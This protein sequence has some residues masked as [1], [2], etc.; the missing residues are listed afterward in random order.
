[1]IE[2]LKSLLTEAK[3]DLESASDDAQVEATRIKYLG[4]KGSLSAVLRGMGK[5]AAEERP[6][7]SEA[8]NQVKAAIEEA[9]ERARSAVRDRALQA[10]LARDKIDVTLPGVMTRT[11]GCF[12]SSMARICTGLVCVRRIRRSGEGAPAGG[13]GS[14]A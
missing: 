2:E 1:M 10:D 13:S 7:V 6:K 12:A 4:K 9:L 3:A 14:V 11:G 8:A 5:L